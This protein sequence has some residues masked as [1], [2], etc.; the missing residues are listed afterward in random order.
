MKRMLLLPNTLLFSGLLLGCASSHHTKRVDPTE[1]AE[2]ANTA[3]V[4]AS[5]RPAISAEIDRWRGE[6]NAFLDADANDPPKQGGVVFVGSSS[7]RGWKS[8]KQDFAGLDV[9]GRGFGGS[10]MID[11]VR[12]ADVLVL[13]RRPSVVVL[14]AGEND[15]AS[16]ASDP[17]EVLRHIQTF[18]TLV[19]RELPRARVVIISIKPSPK[20]VDLT[21][22]Y[23]KANDLIGSFV[24]TDKRLA[25]VD[26]FNAM[27]N[28]NGQPKP[29]LYGPDRLHMTSEGFA[30]WTTLVRLA[31]DHE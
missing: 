13:K 7:I 14:Y 8:L 20:R 6:I 29:E 1:P 25:Y 4:S 28:S 22:T 10:Q 23:R 9:V 5:T 16:G 30:I 27:L 2:H 15:I 3:T 18:V 21:D 19:H 17:A 12:F 24:K 11:V 31:I 26:V